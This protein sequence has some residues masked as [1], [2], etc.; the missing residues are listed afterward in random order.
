MYHFFEMR[1]QSAYIR[2][3][4]RL[5]GDESFPFEHQ[6]D[7]M[8]PK[9]TAGIVP[10]GR[11]RSEALP[12]SCSH[13]D[14]TKHF[15]LSCCTASQVLS[16]LKARRTAKHYGGETAY[17]QH[18]SEADKPHNSESAHSLCQSKHNLH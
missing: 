3:P 4:E 12:R 9:L 18:T 14:T 10:P 16:Q 6:K 13:E 11:S 5:L 1:A 8:L 17:E 15:H 2:V 7:L